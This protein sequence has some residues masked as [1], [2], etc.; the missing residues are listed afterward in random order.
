MVNWSVSMVR[1]WRKLWRGTLLVAP[2]FVLT[3]AHCGPG[4]NSV[5]TIGRQCKFNHNCRQEVERIEVEEKF[6]S[7]LWDYN[8]AD[9][10]LVKLKKRSAVRPVEMDNGNLSKSYLTGAFKKYCFLL[11]KTVFFSL[12]NFDFPR[13]K[14]MGGR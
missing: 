5:L 2:E 10:L 3:A 7:P 8:T 11:F 12:F 9:Y 13:E 6:Y 1:R 4:L 14:V